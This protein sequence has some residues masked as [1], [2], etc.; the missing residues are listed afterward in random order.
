MGIVVVEISDRKRAEQ[1]LELQAVIT[2]NMA[3]GICLVRAMDGVFVY[4]N[5]KFERMFGY[6][7]IALNIQVIY[8]TKS[9]INEDA[10]SGVLHN[11]QVSYF[12]ITIS[13]SGVIIPKKEQSRIFEPFYRIPESERWQQSG[14]GLG[15]TLVKKLV[16]Y[17][18]GRVEVSSSQ[19][20][21][22]FTVQ[23]SL[24]L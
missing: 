1:M 12:Q 9:L 18:Q 3:E 23:L 5:P 11:F 16:E 14:T 10:K 22:T 24:S 8:I 17:L 15:L 2:R 21:T 6:D 19:G 20:W 13:N 4:A 7:S